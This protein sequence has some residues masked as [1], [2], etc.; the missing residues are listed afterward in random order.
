MVVP[1]DRRIV[2]GLIVQPFLAFGL[3]V[4]NGVLMQSG[5]SHVVRSDLM[6]YFLVRGILHAI[7]ATVACVV[8]L[9]MILWLRERGR[10]TFGRALLAGVVLANVPWGLAYIGVRPGADAGVTVASVAGALALGSFFGLTGAGL[11][12]FIACREPEPRTATSVS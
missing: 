4:A 11:F 5:I 10:V 9:P 1:S 7:A 12:W 3:G 2:L 8:A 6:P